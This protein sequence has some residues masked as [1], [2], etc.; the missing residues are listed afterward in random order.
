M[1]MPDRCVPTT[2]GGD[3]DFGVGG[4]VRTLYHNYLCF[5]TQGKIVVDGGAVRTVPPEVV[6][7]LKAVLH[8]G[9]CRIEERATACRD[10]FNACVMAS[11]KE[12]FVSRLEDTGNTD[13]FYTAIQ[14]A[15]KREWEL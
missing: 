1:L 15:V 12:D 5:D 10:V 3:A 14:E 4:D 9:C 11:S 8:A 2:I 6:A 7:M 13:P